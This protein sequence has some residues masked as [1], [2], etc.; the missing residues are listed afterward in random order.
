MTFPKSGLLCAINCKKMF[1]SQDFVLNLSDSSNYLNL[2]SGITN[3]KFFLA[4]QRKLEEIFFAN[5]CCLNFQN[6]AS[7]TGRGPSRWQ[8]CF[9]H[10]EYCHICYYFRLLSSSLAPLTLICL[11]VSQLALRHFAS[12]SH[13]TSTSDAKRY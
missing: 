1:L 5:S 9:C 11:K 7:P 8:V 6:S 2:D 3:L 10:L 4:V 12:A 13:P